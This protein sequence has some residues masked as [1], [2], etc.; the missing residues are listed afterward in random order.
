MATLFERIEDV[1]REWIA[2]QRLFFVGTAPLDGDGHVNVSPKGPIES[3]RVLDDHTV[4]YL[5]AYGSGTETIAH[6]RENGRIVL[7][8][9]AFEG[10]PRILRLHGRGR[11]LQSGTLEYEEL[12][13][14]ANFADPSTPESRRSLIVV[15]VTR[16]ADSCGYGVPEMTF[17]R[18]RE[19]LPLAHAKK[20]RVN[21]ERY[22]E[23]QVTR[24]AQS[25]DGLPALRPVQG[26]AAGDEPDAAQIA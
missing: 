5:D 2:K 14:R 3:L 26:D 13:G 1:H 21:G 9:C 4:A 8:I 10:P 25:I 17:V 12:L 6:L 24:N 16:V 11:V 15:A 23:V 22:R 19:H 7:M 20:E 18:N